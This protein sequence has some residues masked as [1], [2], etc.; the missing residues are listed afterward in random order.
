MYACKYRYIYVY[1]HIHVH[2]YISIHMH[3]YIYIYIGIQKLQSRPA[4]RPP[5]WSA[6]VTIANKY[7]TQTPRGNT[8]GSSCSN[9]TAGTKIES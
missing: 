7:D 4:P 6:A 3:V 5:P 2:I 9:V 8:A 1:I